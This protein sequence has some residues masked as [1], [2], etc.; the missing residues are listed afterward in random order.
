L[1]HRAQAAC[2]RLETINARLY[3]DIRDDIRAGGGPT[4]MLQWIPSADTAASS[5]EG[6]DHLDE[7]LG[8]ILQFD[9]PQPTAV[10]LASEMVFY[11]PTPARHIFEMIV[12]SGLG[13]GDVLVDLGSG[14]GHVPLLAAMCTNASAVGVELE[15]AY[16]ACARQSAASLNLA[17]A[18]FVQCDART[19]DFASGTVFYLYTPFQGTILREVLDRLRQEAKRR[20]IRVCSFGPCTPIIAEEE[21]LVT[22]DAVATDR[23]VVFRSRGN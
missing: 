20:P 11:Q 18:S 14:M 10:E 23:L 2:D 9:E 12:R 22:A 3:E 7:L 4:R 17:N 15:P 13:D 16:I 8:G 19:A 5:Y 6:Y 1:V 21:W